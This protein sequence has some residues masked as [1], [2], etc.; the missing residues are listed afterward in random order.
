MKLLQQ[1]NIIFGLG[2]PRRECEQRFDTYQQRKS[3][4]TPLQ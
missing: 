3:K 1:Q 4:Y 2:K